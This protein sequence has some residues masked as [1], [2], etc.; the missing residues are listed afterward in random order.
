MSIEKHD[1]ANTGNGSAPKVP[2]AVG[3]PQGDLDQ[4]WRFAQVLA[5][6]NLLP[7][8]LRNRPADVLVTI[9]YGQELGLGPM[10]AIQSIHVIKGRPTLSANL[11]VALA[12]KAGH[13]VR[14]GEHTAT[15]CAVTVIRSDDPDGPITAEYTIDDAKTAGLLTNENYRKNPK[16]MLYARAASTAIRQACPEVAM[17]FADEYE[18]ATD[19]PT[20]PTLAA[21]AAERADRPQPPAGPSDD[22]MAEQVAQ[23]AA[24]HE[25][26][27]PTTP[28]A[29]RPQLDK[30]HAFLTEHGI[31]R[32]YKIRL[33]RAMTG[34]RD[35]D[36]ASN[37]TRAE[38][39]RIIDALER[40]VQ[41]GDGETA[42]AIDQMLSHLEEQRG[43][44]A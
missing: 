23:L 18:L 9:L 39:T 12:R 42:L 6:A 44:A 1:P 26:H 11:W 40:L 5:T 33:L 20:R 29:T 31:D 3:R 27:P 24:E 41:D 25:Q 30:L 4:T 43:W 8:E 7:P 22:E 19:E 21:I 35:L 13:K 15:S 37:L 38:T 2:V 28:M 10:Q 14:K 16:A 34:R 32:E 17:G 36:S